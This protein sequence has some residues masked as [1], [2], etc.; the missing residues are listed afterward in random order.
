MFLVYIKL[1][2]R[3]SNGGCIMIRIKLIFTGLAPFGLGLSFLLLG[4]ILENLINNSS[5]MAIISLG[6]V[7][8]WGYF[9]YEVGKENGVSVKNVFY[10]HIIS[11]SLLSL[12]VFVMIVNSLNS[13]YTPV[14][15]SQLLFLPAYQ[16]LSTILFIGT[17]TSI[18]ISF[19][20][21]VFV[22]TIGMLSSKK[23]SFK[24]S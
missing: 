10:T 18:I 11:M 6:F 3:R 22:F 16:F 20:M 2:I 23:R 1:T 4:L 7:W 24:S 8:V 5:F 9:G 19:A 21:M 15:I 17:E 14:F 13:Q 12:Q